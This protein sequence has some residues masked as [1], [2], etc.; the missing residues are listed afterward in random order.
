MSRS[1]D[2]AEKE[3]FFLVR[4]ENEFTGGVFVALTT[5][6]SDFT[7]EGQLYTSETRMTIGLPRNDGAL[8]DEPCVVG[9]PRSLQFAQDI[10]SG[11]RYPSTRMVV[12][13]VVK[14]DGPTATTVNRPFQGR[15]SLAR[16]KVGGRSETITVSAVSIK[17]RL[18]GIP[19]GLPCMQNCINRLGDGYCQKSLVGS[20]LTVTIQLSAIDGA[21]VTASTSI[22][23][24]LEDRFYQRGYMSKDGFEF[25]VRDWRNEVEGDKQV[26]QLVR[27]PPASWIGTNITLVAGCDKTERTCDVRHGNITRFRGP[28]ARMLAY[29]PLYEDG[30]TRQ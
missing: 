30:S 14:G 10:S 6:D 1:I 18:E 9:I 16:R 24:G 5:L 26:F 17:G 22:S 25:M 11:Q 4:F 28:G 8:S 3:S 15:M 20:P 13:E 21:Q 12:I 29:N 19:L 2:Q 7:F 27:Q 23:S